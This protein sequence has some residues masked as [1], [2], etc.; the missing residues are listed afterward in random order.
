MTP[1][2]SAPVFSAV[3][4]LLG[5][6]LVTTTAPWDQGRLEHVAGALAPEWGTVIS[7]DN[8]VVAL[9]NPPRPSGFSPTVIAYGHYCSPTTSSALPTALADALRLEATSPL[10][11]KTDVTA[12][13]STDQNWTFSMSATYTTDSGH[14]AT[15]TEYLHDDTEKGVVWAV[16]ATDADREGMVVMDAIRNPCPR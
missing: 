4:H 16:V 8:V 7:T 14:E 13:P 6:G 2:T 10:Y 9:P 1:A 11:R 3:Q 15:V 12:D 5:A